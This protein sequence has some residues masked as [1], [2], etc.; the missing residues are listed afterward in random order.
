MA[1]IIPT[2]IIEVPPYHIYAL[3]S[4]GSISIKK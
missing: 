2:P 3:F 1:K 4:L